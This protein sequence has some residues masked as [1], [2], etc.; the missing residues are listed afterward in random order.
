MSFSNKTLVS[1]RFL[2]ARFVIP[3]L[4][5]QAEGPAKI[6]LEAVKKTL[7]FQLS[8]EERKWTG[9]IEALRKELYS[10]GTVVTRIIFGLPPEHPS[11]PGRRLPEGRQVTETIGEASRRSSR[12]Y[13]WCLLLFRL[14]RS[15][16]PAVCLEMGTAFGM[17]AAYQAAA[18]CLNQKGRLVTM[19][20]DKAIAPLARSHLESLGLKQADVKVG[21]FQA[22]LKEVLEEYRPIDFVFI[23][24]DKEER[25][26]TGYFEQI[27]PFLSPAAVIVFDDIYWSSGM[28]KAWR[29]IEADQR[30]RI[31]VD[32][33][34]L[35]ICVIDDSLKTKQ[36][37][38]IWIG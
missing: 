9:K 26:V 7:G 13:L 8:A 21:H 28:E 12:Q 29:A 16:K 36:S 33:R 22:I 34:A 30:V 27:L 18:L 23:D 5:R 24:A 19:E 11:P 38:K 4:Y 3:R 20:G 35:G 14:V 17:T 10:S 2:K 15:F 1:L 37:F 25:T 31:S 32:M 6:L